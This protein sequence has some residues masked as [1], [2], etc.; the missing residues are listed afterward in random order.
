MRIPSVHILDKSKQTL[1][2]SSKIHHRSVK[3]QKNCDAFCGA[4]VME[5]YR[6]FGVK[7]QSDHSLTATKYFQ[8]RG[9]V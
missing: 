5:V 1:Q 8:M 2:Q 9:N 4:E 7:S 3:F 6:A